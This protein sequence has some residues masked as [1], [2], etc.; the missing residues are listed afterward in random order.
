MRHPDSQTHGCIY[1]PHHP[2]IVGSNPRSDTGRS[3]VLDY[4]SS[5]CAGEACQGPSRNGVPRDTPQKLSAQD[6]PSSFKR[7]IKRRMGN[8]PGWRWTKS[9]SARHPVMRF[10]GMDVSGHRISLGQLSSSCRG[11]PICPQ[12]VAVLRLVR[13]LSLGCTAREVSLVSGTAVL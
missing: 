10:E 6:Q 4:S 3:Y 2:L 1:K 5:R 7:R 8:C 9:V 11:C 12:S 13:A